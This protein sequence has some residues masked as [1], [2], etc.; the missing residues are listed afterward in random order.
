MSVIRA[1]GEIVQFTDTVQLRAIF[2]DASNTPADLDSFPT[3]SIVQPSGFVAFPPTSAGVYKLTTGTYGFDFSIGINGPI[4]VYV[5]NWAGVMLGIPLNASFNF[6][7]DNTQLPA[8]NSDGY[9]H[10]GDDIGYN[11]SQNAIMNI[12]KVIKV[13]RARLSSSGKAKRID[14][15]GNVQYIDC[16]IFSVDTLT[17]CAAFAMSDFNEC[18]FFTSFTYEDTAIV[19]QFLAVLTEGASIYALAGKSL[20]ERGREFQITDN[21]LSFNPPTVSELLNTQYST[22]LSHHWDKVKYLKNSMR[23]LPK[24]LGTLTITAMN[25][26][27]Q[28][29]RHLRARRFF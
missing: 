23:P 28:R 16:D 22:V 6:I 1:R 5:D 29:M 20:I 13:L 18:P 15:N 12:N 4:G 24:G 3:I 14:P 9:I 11:Y 27:I 7:V 25:P 26:S 21:G 2:K 10:L 19:D 17:T 8:I